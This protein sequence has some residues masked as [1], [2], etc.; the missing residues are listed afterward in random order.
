MDERRESRITRQEEG[1]RGLRR[2]KRNQNMVGKKE[3]TEITGL[4]G[5]MLNTM[6]ETTEIELCI[7]TRMTF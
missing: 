7:L 1:L 2:K 5:F 6:L 4:R 3:G